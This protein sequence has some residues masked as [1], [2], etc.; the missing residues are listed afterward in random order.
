MNIS[1]VSSITAL[2]IYSRAKEWEV[3]NIEYSSPL[4]GVGKAP[5]GGGAYTDQVFILTYGWKLRPVD[6]TEDQVIVVTGTLITDDNSPRTVS[7]IGEG[8]PTWE[9]QVATSGVVTQ[10]N[11][12][13][14]LSQEEH[15]TLAEVARK[16]EF[17]PERTVASKLDI[18]I[19]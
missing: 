3:E 7:V 10:I 13:S 1:G 9:F 14:G 6:Y 11:S 5:L 15:D 17:I 19:K 2:E 12:G 4:L 16:A 8:C 18:L